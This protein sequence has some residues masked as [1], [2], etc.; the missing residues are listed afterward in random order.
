MRWARLLSVGLME[1]S[2]E[3][4]VGTIVAGATVAGIPFSQLS[5]AAVLVRY[6]QNDLLTHLDGW[7]LVFEHG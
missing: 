7:W 3:V 4:I 6:G 1:H 2:M 5:L